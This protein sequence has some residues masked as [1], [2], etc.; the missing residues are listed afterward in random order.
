MSN[1]CRAAGRIPMPDLDRIKEDANHALRS[2]GLPPCAEVKPVADG[3]TMNPQVIGYTDGPTYV[4]KVVYPHATSWHNKSHSAGASAANALRERTKLPIPEHYCVLDEEGRLPLVIMEFMHG[5]QLYCL[6]QR[7]PEEESR[8]VCEDW[9]RCIA[10]FHDPAL[11]DLLDD[12]SA[13][14][15]E[16]E[17]DGQWAKSYLEQ[18]NESDWHRANADRI[19]AYIDKRLPLKGRY[20]IPALTKHGLDVRDFVAVTEPTPHISGMLDWEGIAADDGLV[21]LVGIWVRLHY[22]GVG[23]AAPS[24]LEGYE[25]ERGISLRQS[26]RV[27]FHLMN[28]ALL[29][30]NHNEPSRDIV[31]SL[32]NGKPYPFRTRK[33]E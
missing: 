33:H 17:Y 8:T 9:G 26:K 20:D 32:L 22:L 25:T 13:V 15:R 29:P 28:R 30:T 3:D 2:V 31:E 6:L 1:G 10:A 12:P 18:H 19:L 24:F 14:N 5:E 4:V 16:A 7:A 27:E 23:H 11:F 21:A